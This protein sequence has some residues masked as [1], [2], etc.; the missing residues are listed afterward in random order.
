MF[1]FRKTTRP[2]AQSSNFKHEE[3]DSLGLSDILHV[4]SPV[5]I[6]NAGDGRFRVNPRSVGWNLGSTRKLPSPRNVFIPCIPDLLSPF[7]TLG[8]HHSSGVH[9]NLRTMDYTGSWIINV[10]MSVENNRHGLCIDRN[11]QKMMWHHLLAILISR[12]L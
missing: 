6:K 3:F 4:A 11:I 12:H 9:P 8:S 10:T 1:G 5:S 2:R 7:G